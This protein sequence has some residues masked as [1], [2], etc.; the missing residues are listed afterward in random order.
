MGGTVYQIDLSVI[1]EGE[2]PKY[3]KRSYVGYNND[4]YQV[5]WED[6]IIGFRHGLWDGHDMP[7]GLYDEENL[8]TIEVYKGERPTKFVF[9]HSD[10]EVIKKWAHCFGGMASNTDL[11]LAYAGS[12]SG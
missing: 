2:M 10:V 8:L 4:E 12:E 3:Y 5:S 1:F 11:E 9:Y 6:G 7:T